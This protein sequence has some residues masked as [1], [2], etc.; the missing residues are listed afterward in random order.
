ML[1]WFYAK[2]GGLKDFVTTST[3]SHLT[4]E[5]LRTIPIPVPPISLQIKYEKIISSLKKQ[6]DIDVFNLSN[7]LFQTL[8]QK[9]FNNELVT[10]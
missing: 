1:F 10:E 6:I 3:I 8:L 7:N 5:K 9:A 2:F 4:G